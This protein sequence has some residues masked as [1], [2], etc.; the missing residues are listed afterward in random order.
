MGTITYAAFSAHFPIP[1]FFIFFTSAKKPAQ[2]PERKELRMDFELFKAPGGR[3]FMNARR[4][5]A[6]LLLIFIHPAAP[7][8]TSPILLCSKP[9]AGVAGG[10]SLYCHSSQQLSPAAPQP[11]WL[12]LAPEIALCSFRPGLSPLCLPGFGL[13]GSRESRNRE[14]GRQH[15]HGGLL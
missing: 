14:L 5:G 7:N 2:N 15:G 13:K 3:R 10:T 11:R 4:A 8:A 6:S 12:A 1:S 9:A